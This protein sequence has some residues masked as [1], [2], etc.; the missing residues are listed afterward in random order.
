MK[1][2]PF[3]ISLFIKLDNKIL[4]K[5]KPKTTSQDLVPVYFIS[6]I[7]MV[8]NLNAPNV[9]KIHYVRTT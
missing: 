2:C 4:K 6:R 8:D 1:I 5:S 7:K 3:Y 9:Y